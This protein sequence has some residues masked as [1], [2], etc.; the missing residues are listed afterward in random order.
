[1]DNNNPLQKLIVDETKETNLQ[2]L[3]GVLESYVVFIKSSEAIN[4]LPKFQK[5]PNDLKILVVLASS[6]ARAMLFSQQSEGMSQK[7]FISLDIAPEGSIKA[8]LKK[9]FDG[10]EIKSKDKKYYLP[11]YRISS[12]AERLKN[13]K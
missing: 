13:I 5:L 7:D 10:K 11:S 8:T 12:L 9:L 6:K 2:E 3:A 1:M 4:L